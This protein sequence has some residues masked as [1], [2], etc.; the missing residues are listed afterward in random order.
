ADPSNNT[1]YMAR[2]NAATPP[3]RMSSV[4]RLSKPKAVHTPPK[5]KPSPKPI[6]RTSN[7]GSGNAAPDVVW[8]AGGGDAGLQVPAA[9]ARRM[10]QGVVAAPAAAK[11]KTSPTRGA[12][13]GAKKKGGPISLAD[14]LA[15]PKVAAAKPEPEARPAWNEDF[16]DHAS[17]R[18][19]H[20][21]SINDLDSPPKGGHKK[22][23]TGMALT[24]KKAA[25]SG[26][27]GTLKEHMA[28]KRG[29]GAGGG[30]GG[31]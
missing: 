22:G 11:A 18:P 16:V 20:L 10:S 27:G 29:G 25:G 1:M 24:R 13:G 5:K 2:G 19:E 4:D 15:K 8:G 17:L 30:G 31:G 12:G 7:Q 26:A 6:I 21:G 3:R 23:V 14:L 28:A 9:T